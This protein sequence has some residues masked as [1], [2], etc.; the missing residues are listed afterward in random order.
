MTDKT[1]TQLCA[2]AL[3]ETKRR[4]AD[5]VEAY[6]E[7]VRTITVSIEKNDLQI[8]RSHKETMVG[9]R[10]LVGKRVGFASTNDPG[11]IDAACSDAVVLAKASPA[12]DRNL[13][14]QDE[15]VEP[16]DGIYD[17]A[18]ETFTTE[19]ATQRAVEMIDLAR[20]MDDRLILGDGEFSVHIGTRALA[21]S[22]G[23]ARSETESLFVYFA[24]ATARD[25]EH[26]SNMDFQFGAARSA[27]AID[28][29]PVVRRACDNA[30]GSLGAEAGESFSGPILLSPNAALDILAGL[31]LFQTNAKNALR[32]M[33]RWKEAVGTAVASP[34]LT[35]VDDGRAPKG[36]GTASFDRE[37]VGHKRLELVRDGRLTSLL[38]NTYTA[39]ALQ[40]KNTGHAAGS[41]RSLPG[42]GPTNFEILPGRTTKDELISEMKKGVL[43]TR[44]SGRTDPISGDFSGVAKGAYLIENGR[45]S[46]PIKGTLIAG[47]VFESLKTVSG[48]SSERERV[49]SFTLPYL[50]LEGISVTAG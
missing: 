5:E 31:I 12:D 50:R 16:V 43:V 49:F 46:R 3:E 45:I 17:P 22:K 32:G 21:T 14:P 33:S 40:T 47:N 2:R 15:A 11:A 9:V 29:E 20:S 1:L 27:A 48:V 35:V 38:H 10:A 23:I 28:T 4:G 8:S 18:A 6:G 13:L 7:S 39:A 36:V 26:V 42:I 44:F 24:L 37:G 41:A 34:L 30:L 25:G 19:Q